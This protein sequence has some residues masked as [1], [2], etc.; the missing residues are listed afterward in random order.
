ML[1]ISPLSIRCVSVHILA[2]AQNAYMDSIYNWSLL[3]LLSEW[4]I[5]LIM[6]VYV[7]RERSAAAARTWL[8][9]IF[10][11]PWPGLILYGLIGRVYLP[12]SRIEQQRRASEQ[13]RK[14]Q[15]QIRNRIPTLPPLPPHLQ[16]LAALATRLGDFE[17][18]GGN[19]V[20]LL[21]DYK[22]SLSRLIAE[23]DSARTHVHLLYYIY[24]DD[25]F[26][27]RVTDALIRA[28]KRGVQCRVLLDAVGSKAA[29]RRQAPQMRRAGIEVHAALQ[30]KLFRRNSA[31]FD[32]RNHRKIAVIDGAIAYT[33]SQNIVDGE[34][35]PGFPNE[36]LVMRVTG[37]VVAQLQAVF[38]ADRFF[39]TGTTLEQAQA[40]PDLP[41]TGHT[42]AQVLPSGPGYQRDNGQEI[43]V[44]LLYAARERVVLTTPY[45][46][47]DE[48]F[49][50]A[51]RSA[52][53]RGL[54]VHLVV[55]RHANQLFTQLAQRSYYDELLENGVKIHIYRP[56]FLHAKH[57]SIDGEIAL[58][59]STNIDIRSF[60][61]NA[62]INLLVYDPQIMAELRELQDSYFANSELLTLEEWEKRPLWARTLHG[63]ARLADSLL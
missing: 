6:L 9:L 16:P 48:P 12:K 32:L 10:L 43:M 40:F 41:E 44:S 13:I 34:F 37:P 28:A 19:T 18:F 3:Y 53:R 20:E 11:L 2:A 62:E 57:L 38:V 5:R 60:A 7:P 1:P 59:G 23:I 51:L 21:T 33:G 14:V 56:R 24:G 15:D 61:L 8:L 27:Q 50:Q 46:V 35:V 26:G 4:A 55:S 36:E 29:L 63:V 39:E 31:R 25:D 49:F 54:E 30:V 17:P 52:A 45:F 42:I 47:P 22:G 58:I